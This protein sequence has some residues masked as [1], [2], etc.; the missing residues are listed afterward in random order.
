[1]KKENSRGK[2]VNF[3]RFVAVA[4]SICSERQ[5][6]WNIEVDADGY[7][8]DGGAWDL[9][10]IARSPRSQKGVLRDLGADRRALALVVADKRANGQSHVGDRRLTS[11]WM[12]LLKAVVIDWI[13]IRKNRPNTV[14]DRRLRP[15]RIL[16]VCAEESAPWELNSEHVRVALRVSS[17]VG[18]TVR[19]DVET[20]VSLVFDLNGLSSNCPLLDLALGGQPRTDFSRSCSGT[21]I[22]NHLQE[23]KA[24]E[25]LPEWRAFWELVRIV[26]TEQPQT[27]LDALR[28]DHCK[29][30]ICTGFRLG[31]SC[32]IPADWRRERAV[33]TIDG[34][35]MDTIGGIGRLLYIRHF[36]EKQRGNNEDSSVL[37]EATQLVPRIFEEIIE[38]SFDGILRRTAPLRARLELQ[39][40]TGR[41]FPEYDPS[42]L[43][44]VGEFY[45]RL[46]GNLRLLDDQLPADLVKRYEET[47]DSELL[48]QL[49]ETQCPA[50]LFRKDVVKYF[51]QFGKRACGRSG[52]MF[53]ARRADG[54]RWTHPINWIDAYVWVGEL[55]E[56]VRSAM[57]RKLPD[58]I[59]YRL[60]NGSLLFPHEL[61]FLAPK[62]SLT[63]QR[64]GNILDVN[65]YFAIGTVDG[66]DLARSLG[67]K[68]MNLFSRYGRTDEDRALSLTKTHHFRHL[69]NTELFR[70][71]LADTIISKRFNRKSVHQNGIYDH[72]SLSE[73]LA[74]IDLPRKTSN[75]LPPKAQDTL[76]LIKTGQVAGRIVDEFK[77]VQSQEGEDA[78]LQFLAAEADGFHATPYGFCLNSFT[79]D[80]CPK[81]L[82]CFNGCRHFTTTK[83]SSH[84]ANLAKIQKQLETAAATIEARPANS[85]GHQNQLTDVRR[86]LVNVRRAISAVPGDRPFPDGPDLFRGVGG[87]TLLDE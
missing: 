7:V 8:V 10:A 19:A 75:K 6:D 17:K 77:R 79:V 52:E 80:P 62:A 43:V 28:F 12:D 41:L 11:E 5:I 51:Y 46:S 66:Q 69:Q 56:V 22:R 16:A 45:P 67:S 30:L 60:P 1:M 34:Q 24:A 57:P 53:P 47:F 61:L 36:A 74:R 54:S 4:R 68:P 78:A 20:V 40:K 21:P 81:H 64:N 25:K 42:D 82:E 23:R 13:V 39:A 86:K 29:I 70:A 9:N 48:D 50:D 31:E 27:F 84:H 58:V 38:E 33:Q 2:N 85:V 71:G 73:Y 83:D 14:Y 55:E 18:I 65:R 76:K 59:P 72:R 37:Y 35:S 63:D 3:D 49:W 87:G 44:P 32:I 15:L 26:F